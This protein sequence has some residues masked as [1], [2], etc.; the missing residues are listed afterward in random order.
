MNWI[1]LAVFFCPKECS[2][3]KSRGPRVKNCF[4]MVSRRKTLILSKYDVR[5]S[6]VSSAHRA[7]NSAWFR[8]SVLSSARRAF[9]SAWFRSSGQCLRSSEPCFPALAR[10]P[11]RAAVE[12]LNLPEFARAAKSLRSSDLVK[13]VIRNFA[14]HQIP[15]N[16]Q[17]CLS[18]NKKKS[19]W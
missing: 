8:S 13:S 11:C 4:Y 19:K 1:I 10:A 12:R 18:S 17:L 2:P 15:P 16:L 7:F 9:D 5:S 3:V 14:S 6:G